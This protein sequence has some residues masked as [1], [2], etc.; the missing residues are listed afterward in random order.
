MQISEECLAWE[1]L[2][3]RRMRKKRDLCSM[4]KCVNKVANEK[5]LRWYE[6]GRR[7]E[8]NRMVKRIYVNEYIGRKNWKTKEVDG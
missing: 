4:R 1:K 2:T 6:H 5:V 7:M 8:K 3:E